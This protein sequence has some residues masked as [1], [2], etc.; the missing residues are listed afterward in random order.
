MRLTIVDVEPPDGHRFEHHVVRLNRVA[1][2][3]VL[4]DADEV[5]MLWRHRFVDDS[6]GWELPG[7][8][9][10]DGEE[11][12]ECAARE[13]EEE[14]GWWPGPGGTARGLSAHARHVSVHADPAVAACAGAARN[15]T[16]GG[17]ADGEHS[18]G[19]C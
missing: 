18:R 11:P 3:V 17:H 12:A 1:I 8:I 7:G 6:W 10:E 15:A 19:D 14:T 16:G 5:L 2:A 13:V 9:V 4:N